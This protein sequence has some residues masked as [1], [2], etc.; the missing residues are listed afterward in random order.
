MIEQGGQAFVVQPGRGGDSGWRFDFR[1]TLASESQSF[2]V[3]ASRQ[4]GWGELPWLRMA[5]WVAAV[6]AAM[7]G[8]GFLLRQRTARRRAEELLRLGHVGRLNAL[9]ELA[10]GMAHE[11]N[12]PLTAVLANTQAARR[13]LQDDPPELATARREDAPLTTP[14]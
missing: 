5:A 2:D 13:L 10:A 7:T 14:Q 12:Q 8:V 9:G 11:L 4:V 3:V 1:K 6:G